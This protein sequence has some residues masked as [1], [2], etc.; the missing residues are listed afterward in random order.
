MHACTI[1]VRMHVHGLA[2]ELNYS[3][4]TQTMHTIAAPETHG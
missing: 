3:S 2:A 4:C 1:V